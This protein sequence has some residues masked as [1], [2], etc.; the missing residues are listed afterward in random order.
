MIKGIE[1]LALDREKVWHFTP[2]AKVGDVLEAGDVIGIVKETEIVD[3]R[4]MVPF[5]KGGEVVSIT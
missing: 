3:H 5:N 1:A 2:V 4:I